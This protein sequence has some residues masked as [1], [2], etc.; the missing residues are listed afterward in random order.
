MLARDCG[1]YA[2]R[3]PAAH[4]VRDDAGRRRRR[5]GKSHGLRI[6]GFRKRPRMLACVR[7]LLLSKP[8]QR[9]R[10]GKRGRGGRKTLPIYR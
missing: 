3:N 9:L 8:K 1:V 2:N 7:L 6:R 5:R 10:L 4:E